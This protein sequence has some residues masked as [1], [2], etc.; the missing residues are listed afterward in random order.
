MRT[1]I[2]AIAALL[3][4]AL[5]AHADDVVTVVTQNGQKAYS[6]DKL[7]RIQ[8]NEDDLTVVDT[9]EKGTTYA[10][11]NVQ[12]I[13]ISLDATALNDATA[14]SQ[15]ALTL[16]ISK[17]G[18]EMCVDGW[19]SSQVASLRVYDASGRSVMHSERWQGETIDISSLPQGVY[20]VKAGTHTAKFRK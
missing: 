13:L 4:T 5:S 15:P 17:D 11:D 8:L 1:R 3:V 16:T 18:T 20:V 7:S 9:N 14:D 10:F 19:D 2:I 12:R 6:M